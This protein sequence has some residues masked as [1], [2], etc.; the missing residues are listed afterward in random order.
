MAEEQKLPNHIAI[1]LDGNGR[2]AKRRGM[3]R[4]Y[5]HIV[6]TDVL[7]KMCN[8][9]A[10]MGV[11]YLTVYAF[12][13]E[14]WK[15]AEEEVRTL[16]NLFRKYLVRIEKSAHK[17]HMRVRII[18][19]KAGLPSDIQDRIA[20]LEDVT[21]DYD[22]MDF[23]IALNYGGRDEITRAVNSLVADA[24]DGKL[25]E[26]RVTE[27]MIAQ[28]LDTGGIP[29]PDLMIRTGGEKRISNFL[30]WQL[31]YTE[32]YFTDVAWPDFDR[33]ELDRA[34]DYYNHRDRR[35]GNAK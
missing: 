24:R 27:E 29:D 13:T 25:P 28:R 34:I 9:I 30:L 8:T 33:A 20:V 11:R 23:Q 3:P 5:G 17:R 35:F 18:G 21:K 31:A 16:M 2:W 10:D 7:E 6:G 32:F 1:I 14:N 15:R 19:D 26:G 4:S 12:S 22:R